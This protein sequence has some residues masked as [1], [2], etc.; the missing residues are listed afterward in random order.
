MRPGTSIVWYYENIWFSSQ[1]ISQLTI[2]SDARGSGFGQIILGVSIKLLS[3]STN[4]R[5]LTIQLN[6]LEQLNAELEGFAC[7]LQ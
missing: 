7:N 4:Y 3:L 5:H 1:E 6:R 2:S